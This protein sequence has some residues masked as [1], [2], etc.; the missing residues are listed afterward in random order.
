MAPKP[1]TKFAIDPDLIR[2]LADILTETG[3]GEIEY[4]EGDRRIRVARPMTAAGGPGA[5]AISANGAPATASTPAPAAGPP[6]GALTAPMV[7]TVYLAPEPD[8]APFVR[9]GDKVKEGQTLLIIEA[10]KVMNPIRSPRAGELKQVL[11]A[12]GQPVEYG[13]PLLVIE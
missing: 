5:T 3:L 1:E 4:A 8:A 11:V 6:A 9:V 13:E 12:N 7:G 10:M 2:A